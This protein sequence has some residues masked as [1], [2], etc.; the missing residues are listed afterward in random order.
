[1]QTHRQ[2]VPTGR[3]QPGRLA[4][5]ASA[6]DSHHPEVRARA[7]AALRDAQIEVYCGDLV[8]AAH[9]IERARHQLQA[10]PEDATRG[11]WAALEQAATHVRRAQTEAAADAVDS[12]WQ[13]LATT[14]M[15]EG[16]RR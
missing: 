2:S 1:M 6:D 9:S 4:S 12:A 14:E 8:L 11:E 15:Q 16:H 3:V 5:V 10:H 7:A 13:G